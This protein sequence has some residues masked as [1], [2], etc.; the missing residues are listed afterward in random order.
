MTMEATADTIRF[1]SFLPDGTLLDT[2]EIR[3]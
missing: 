3:K 1:Q 2:A